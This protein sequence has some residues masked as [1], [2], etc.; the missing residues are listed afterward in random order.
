VLFGSRARGDEHARSD[1]DL[2]VSLRDGANRGQLASRLSERLGLRVQLVT[3]EDA[4]EA[5]LLL[6]EVIR[7]GRVVVDRNGL[8][9]ALLRE[10]QQIERAA[11]RERRRIDAE[12]SAVFGGER[13]A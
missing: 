8:W 4:R 10:T 7:E 11:T 9:P 2:L 3:L 6:A 12:F 5:P 13:A 1:V